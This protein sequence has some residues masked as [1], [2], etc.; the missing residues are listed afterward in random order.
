MEGECEQGGG[1]LG[2]NFYG[3]VDFL[4]RPTV[5]FSALMTGRLGWQTTARFDTIK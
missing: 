2:F 1:A 4:R 3:C 5:H